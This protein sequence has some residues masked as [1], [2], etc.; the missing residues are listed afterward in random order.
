MVEDVYRTVGSHVQM[1]NSNNDREADFYRYLTFTSRCYS[2][3][4]IS[5]MIAIWSNYNN[6]KM[7]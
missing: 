4:G 7:H 5:L 1:G 3:A 6:S 2:I